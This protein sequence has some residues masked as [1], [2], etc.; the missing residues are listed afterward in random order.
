M[1]CASCNP[2]G[3][4]PSGAAL[5]SSLWTA[6]WIPGYQHQLYGR[7]PLS[8][9][10]SRLFFNS[11]DA[12]AVQDVNGVQ[13]VYQ[14]EAMGTG[15]CATSNPTYS[16][17]SQG[18]IGLISS[19]QSPRESE[20]VDASASGDDVFIRTESSLSPRDPGLVDIYDARVG[21]GEAQPLTPPAC[22]GDACQNVPPAPGFA[23]PASSSYSGPGNLTQRK[24]RCAKGK[25]RRRGRCVK[26][27]RGSAKAKRAKRERR[28]RR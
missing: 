4:R 14:W 5:G 13:D 19:G 7:R 11:L 10:G 21:G 17:Q 15:D 8:E 2:S 27:H 12:L 26:R 22:E 18:C 28:A 25:V 23:S 24:P 3:G 9:D 1:I 20:F 16:A 6:A